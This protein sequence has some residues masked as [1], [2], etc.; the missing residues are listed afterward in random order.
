MNKRLVNSLVLSAALLGAW[1]A[2]AAD[3]E[4]SARHDRDRPVAK[5]LDANGRVVGKLVYFDYGGYITPYERLA[6]GGVI[7][8]IQGVLVYASV[9]RSNPADESVRE[10]KWYGNPG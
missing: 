9:V 1:P 6:Q 7:L 2:A 10:L 3:E 5:L 4:D 8:N